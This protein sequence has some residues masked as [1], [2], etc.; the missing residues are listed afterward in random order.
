MLVLVIPKTNSSSVLFIFNLRLHLIPGKD[1]KK[2]VKI[3]KD[4]KKD[5]KV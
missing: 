3:C 5:L 1:L 2:S 4:L